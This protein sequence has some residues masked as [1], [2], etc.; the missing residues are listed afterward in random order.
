MIFAGTCVECC[1]A[2]LLYSSCRIHTRAYDCKSTRNYTIIITMSDEVEHALQVKVAEQEE[3]LAKVTE[4][5]DKEV[6]RDPPNQGLIQARSR[7]VT[8]YAELLQV[9][10]ANLKNAQNERIKKSTVAAS[11]SSS[12]GSSFRTPVA[13]S[14]VHVPPPKRATPSS[15]S[16]PAAAAAAAASSS[17]A[18]MRNSYKPVTSSF[19]M[20]TVAMPCSM[21]TAQQL[22]TLGEFFLKFTSAAPPAKVQQQQPSTKGGKTTRVIESES[23]S[24]SD[25][26]SSEEEDDDA[27]LNAITK[28]AR[29]M[30]ISSSSKVPI[31]K[32]KSEP[33]HL[34][35]PKFLAKM[36]YES[37]SRVAPPPSKKTSIAPS[38]EWLK[39]VKR[40]SHMHNV[41][42]LLRQEVISLRTILGITARSASATSGILI[43]LEQCFVQWLDRIH[44]LFSEQPSAVVFRELG[45]RTSQFIQMWCASLMCLRELAMSCVTV[46][47]DKQPGINVGVAYILMK[48]LDGTPPLATLRMRGEL[49]GDLTH[50]MQLV[51]TLHTSD[52]RAHPIRLTS[53]PSNRTCTDEF[54]SF[55]GDLD[56]VVLDKSIK[57][58]LHENKRIS[59]ANHYTAINSKFVRSNS[60]LVSHSQ[61]LASRLAHSSRN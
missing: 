59:D 58:P 11:S 3:E 18:V 22:A 16:V 54:L 45:I 7:T 10:R 42:I 2:L 39:V 29:K 24:E 30:T 28:K 4:S 44:P 12:F 8:K 1:N 57:Q 60:E 25:S 52:L 46:P 5:Y 15:S 19:A 6:K 21:Y 17:S 34:R 9:A 20:D 26:E 49:D 41:I 14:S 56:C 23:E 61:A 51:R 43:D 31:K 36:L 48:G 38:P 32:T 40:A 33:V 13:A 47:T 53:S 35:D 27:I 50:V 55:L 37:K